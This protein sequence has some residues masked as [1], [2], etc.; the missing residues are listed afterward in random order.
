MS[1]SISRW[2][3]ACAAGLIVATAQAASPL[4]EHYEGAWAAQPEAQSLAAHRA[5]AEAGARAAAAWT[6]EPPTLELGERSDRWQEDAGFRERELGVAVPL[7]WPGERAG[8]RAVAAATAALVESGQAAARLRLAGELRERWWQWQAAQVAAGLAADREAR[9][10]QLAA[11][12]ARRVTAGELAPVDRLQA[13]AGVAA[14]EAERAAAEAQLAAA[15]AA[16]QALGG[17]L[18]ADEAVVG[19]ASSAATK[20]DTDTGEAAEPDAAPRPEVQ[21]LA[22]ADLG[23]PGTTP[24]AEPEPA[25]PAL[26]PEGHP[27]LVAA[28]DRLREA[29]GA[30][31]LAA[32]QRGANPE[33]HV[34]STRERA[35][36][37]GPEERTLTLGLSLPL[38]GGARRR[39]DLARAEAAV[40]EA[41]A[42]LA[43][44]AARL[45]A[46]GRAAEARVRAA[47]QRLAA[48]HTRAR[49]AELARAAQQTA[50]E[51]GE[52]DLPTRLRAEGEAA[53]A[54]R[55]AAL[56]RIELAAAISGWR[57]AL[58]LLPQ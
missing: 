12:V 56:A 27:A 49:L 6:P 15:V 20:A 13:E 9:A 51:A 1:M 53:E 41:R 5:A 24:A 44:E 42:A 7:W 4:A 8:A 46:E 22:A 48:H 10:R 38:G 28:R 32:A 52:T 25:A 11:D 31:A 2:I 57:Q 17:T 50:F 43:L 23:D 39:A 37:G 18:P 47:R 30:A 55:E 35:L 45:A 58:G 19:G 21:T 33:L 3:P 36:L 26:A 40:D 29:E 54:E 34:G 16:L 14:A